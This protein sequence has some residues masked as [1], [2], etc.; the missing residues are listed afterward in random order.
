[1]S[2]RAK[3][4][5]NPQSNPRGI[6]KIMSGGFGFVQTAEGE[7]F[8]PASKIKGAFDGD[9]VEVALVSVNRAHHQPTK[10]H[11]NTG[12]K[13]VAR[14]I[15]VIQHAHDTLIGR[16]EIAEPFGVVIPLDK[17]ISYDIFTMRAEN[18][19]VQEG[20]IVRVRIT[21]Y[22]SSRTAALGVIEEVVGHG[23]EETLGV[24]MIIARHKLATQFSPAALEQARES[25]L[26]T[27]QALEMGYQD[28]R[29]RVVFTIDPVDAQDFDDAL[30]LEEEEGCLR[31]GVHI[32][33]VSYYVG[34]NSAI[35]LDAQ[36]RATSV[37]LV[38]RVL[39]MLPEAL[40]AD[41]CS[42]KPCEERLSMTVDM[43]LDKEFRVVR[44][45]VY[46][47][48]I[49]SSARFT[50]EEVQE[51]LEKANA[52]PSDPSSLQTAH[53]SLRARPAILNNNANLAK[54]ADDFRE[55][56]AGLD[57]IACALQQQR[58]LAGGIDFVS[59]EA[60]VV[61]DD[62]GKP[63]EIVL[64]R[65]TAATCL[66]EEAMILANTT[67]AKHLLNHGFPGLFRVHEKPSEDSLSELVLILRE[68]DYLNDIDAADFVAGNPF[69][70]QE[71]LARCKGK[72]EEELI[73][74]LVLR[75]MK[76]A[77][78]HEQCLQHY[79]LALGEY[80]HFTSPI[81]RYPDLVIHR[82]LKAQLLGRG[83]SYQHEADSL[84][85]L[86]EKSSEAERIAEAAARESQEL[87]IV[88][89]MQDDVGCVFGAVISGVTAYGFFVRLANT[90]EGLVAA[91]NLGEEYFAYDAKRHTLVGEESGRR[92]RLGQKVKVIL[93]AADTRAGHLDF[94][95]SD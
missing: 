30:S 39:P 87:K 9:I 76:R 85:R 61:L 66:V 58:K 82:M 47:A 41:I 86:A 53:S 18:P 80:C 6:L 81:R 89:Y 21:E 46:P 62:A 93:E 71:V 64:R 43:Y 60:K 40:S 4:R 52:N 77:V 54:S 1:M 7:F 49:K 48:V 19:Q 5:R 10:P 34:W 17:R 27:K 33:D 31:L 20:D 59:S 68:F 55:H 12:E 91:K 69:R 2:A 67:V 3:T 25:T 16:Y 70:I 24:E 13:P 26:D 51:T 74:S 35:D 45:E 95:L 88:E 14:V 11:A 44:Y 83:E 78:Y 84:V 37:Y 28:L 94:A 50:Y 57:K 15:R 75:A 92:F 90:A 73:S 23:E 65:K 42:L 79:A 63:L 38:D 72:P 32:A 8:V 29:E 56:F 22:P 36:A